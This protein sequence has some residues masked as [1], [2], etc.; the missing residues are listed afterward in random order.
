MED[1]VEEE[2]TAWK[3]S[4]DAAEPWER[5][6]TANLIYF[7]LLFIPKI[8]KGTNTFSTELQDGVGTKCYM[9]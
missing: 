9:E 4:E 1:E 8:K 5:G 7:F 3:K 2:K 6:F